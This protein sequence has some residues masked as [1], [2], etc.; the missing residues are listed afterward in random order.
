M[1]LPE[2]TAAPEVMEEVELLLPAE[3]AQQQG[4]EDS[5]NPA[6]DP[7][8]LPPDIAKPPE[9]KCPADVQVLS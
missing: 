5:K 6:A 3:D 1:S 8:W 9:H 4:K 7:F 2:A